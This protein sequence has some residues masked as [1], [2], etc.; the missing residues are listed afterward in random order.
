MKKII[1]FLFTILTFQN[2]QAQEIKTMTYFQNDTIK[3]DLDL[4]L[5]QKKQM[6]KFR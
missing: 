1:I 6:K 3:L 4:Y 5:P 2:I